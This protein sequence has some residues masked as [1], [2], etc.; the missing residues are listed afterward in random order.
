MDSVSGYFQ[1]NS[2]TVE[3]LRKYWLPL[4][5]EPLTRKE[6]E[7]LIRIK[8]SKYDDTMVESKSKNCAM[9]VCVDGSIR[10]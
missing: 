5:V 4:N 9:M 1:S 6:L 10:C 2:T 7:K 8:V 3:L